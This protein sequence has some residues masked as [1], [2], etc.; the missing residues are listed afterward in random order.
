[1]NV[2]IVKTKRKTSCLPCR[3]KKVKCDGEL[4]C[5]RCVNKNTGDQCSYAQQRPLGRRPKNAVINKL[6][7]DRKRQQTS[8]EFC[9][10]F[11]IENL[12]YTIPSGT[13]FLHN[14]K[15]KNLH[16]FL[17]SYF[18]DTFA[19]AVTQL[20]MIRLS[21]AP[22]VMPEVKMYDLLETHTWT[23]I[24]LT[25][26]F[27]SSISTI[28]QEGAYEYN[29][30]ASGVFQDLAFKFFAELP[31]DPYSINPLTTLST[32]Q[33]IRLIECFFSIHPF[34]QLLNKTL[35][36]Q[37][38]WTDSVD[39]LLLCAVYGT[40]IYFSR[41]LE[42]RPVGLWEAV[43]RNERNPYLDYAY[44]LLQKS[45]TEATVVKYQAVILLGMFETSYG[46][47]KRGMSLLGLAYMMG[48]KLGITD[49]SLLSTEI[50][51]VEAELLTNTYWTNFNNIIR[52]CVDVGHA[53]HFTKGAKNPPPLPPVNIE[54][55]LSYQLELSS[56]DQRLYRSYH[57]LV[58]TFYIVCVISTYVNKLLIQFPE[59]KY[60]A[61]T[62]HESKSKPPVGH[63]TVDDLVPRLMK[64]LQEFDEFIQATR[65]TWTAQ[66]A[67]TIE[68]MW[69][70]FDIHILFIKDYAPAPEGTGYGNSIFDIFRD[71]VLSSNDAKTMARVQM[72]VPK[73][74]KML[75]LMQ[76]FLSEKS[77][78]KNQ[79]SLLP[80]AL[81]LSV[82]ETAT[83]VLCLK[84]Y[85]DRQ[86][87]ITWDYLKQIS[88]LT[89]GS[90]WADW[91]TI[92]SV[93][94]K[95]DYYLD[96]FNHMD[97]ERQFKMDESTSG[98]LD[99][100][101]LSNIISSPSSSSSSRNSTVDDDLALAAFFD[102]CAEWLT[103][104]VGTLPANLVL[105][106]MPGDNS[107]QNNSSNITSTNDIINN[108]ISSPATSTNLT[109][110]S[111]SSTTVSTLPIDNIPDNIMSSPLQSL[112]MNINTTSNYGNAPLGNQSISSFNLFNTGQVPQPAV[113]SP[114]P[115]S[116]FNNLSSP[117]PPQP[118][119]PQQ[120]Q[121]QHQRQ[122]S[123][124]HTDI[125]QVLFD[126]PSFK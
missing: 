65:H 92:K 53:A 43:N 109:S 108:F 10:D 88:T 98:P 6:V 60:N 52:G 27:N 8:Y 110:S 95:V 17:D 70:L 84:H 49:G 45:S 78:Y 75:D 119:P 121:Q 26:I 24:E 14:D 30:I 55:S 19:A 51:D 103:P 4:P 113:T 99:S 40:A 125:Q 116:F 81:L 21:N 1:M 25:N 29:S 124:Y 115:H 59:V 122:E 33:A 102:P 93:R 16:Y 39:P 22:S 28:P 64:V 48:S 74:Y 57:Y 41:M 38:F 97:N 67:Y 2:S 87:D 7:L 89:R 13:K 58:E 54:K 34:S 32:Q 44:F 77:N 76:A 111:S 104:L 35:L 42:G 105:W 18:T 47:P 86:D 91:T 73:V 94:E 15:T 120:Q 123:L 101:V 126:D 82:L 36:L 85:N 96:Q 61:T 114:Q 12:A 68:S 63:P 5:Q 9:K 107:I 72:G 46:F 31:V 117:L 66:Q 118:S 69:M 23:A 80:R 112:H 83:T 71:T 90:I 106:D 62:T 56:G 50:S 11:I 20:A 37:G 100:S 3:S 79:V